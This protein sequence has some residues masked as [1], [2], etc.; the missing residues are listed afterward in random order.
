MFITLTMPLFLDLFTTGSFLLFVLL[1]WQTMYVFTFLHLSHSISCP[2][3]YPLFIKISTTSSIFGSLIC[4]S[5][6]RSHVMVTLFDDA[7]VR[8]RPNVNK[9]AARVVEVQRLDI[10]Y[11]SYNEVYFRISQ[12]DDLNYSLC[13]VQ[14]KHCAEFLESVRSHRLDYRHEMIS[15]FCISPETSKHSMLEEARGREVVKY[16]LCI[17]VLNGCH[18]WQ[19]VNL[20]KA[21]GHFP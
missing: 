5:S 18:Y 19:A 15:N 6:V 1:P 13:N 21:K 9:T 11:Y 20:L 2:I 17:S 8:K 14:D 10:A 12:I 7:K 16:R 3:R 4:G